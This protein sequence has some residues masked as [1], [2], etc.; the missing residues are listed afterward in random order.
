MSD[1]E[2]LKENNLALGASQKNAIAIG[3]ESILNED[4]LRLENEMM[5]HKFSMQLATSTY[6]VTTW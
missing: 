6:S 5:K 2:A 1:L 3:E 4:C